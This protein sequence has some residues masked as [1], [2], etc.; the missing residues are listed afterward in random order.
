MSKLLTILNS[1]ITKTDNGALAYKST[2]NDIVDFFA[3]AGAM[4]EKNEC[5]IINSFDKAF[6][7]DPLVALKLLFYFRDCREGVG[8]RRLFRI[9]SEHLAQNNPNVLEK[10][11][12][13]IPHFGRWD[14]LLCLL[15]TKCKKH[16]IQLIKEQ[17]DH[18]IAS[19]PSLLGKWLPS[20]NTSSYKTQTL[21]RIICKELKINEKQYRKLLSCLRNKISIVE[22]KISNKD[23][24]NIDYESVPSQANLKYMKAFWRNDEERYSDFVTKAV[25]GEK[26]IKTKTLMPYEIIRRI[27]RNENNNATGDALWN[28]LPNYA[29]NDCDAIVVADTS[30]SMLCNNLLPICTAISLAI[31]FAER[32]KGVFANHFINFSSRPQLIKIDGC[33]I[34]AKAKYV[35]HKSLIDNT[36]IEAVFDLIL[37]TAIENQLSDSD[38]PERIIIISDMQFDMASTHRTNNQVLFDTIKQ[39]WNENDYKM[40]KLVYWNVNATTTAHPQTCEDENVQFVSGHSA[41]IFN[42]ILQDKFCT[43][44]ELI[45]DIVNKKRYSCIAM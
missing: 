42:E 34:T 2:Q 29:N 32:N 12:I 28:N 44:Y 3:T 4:R 43:P 14:D 30:G 26:K 35:F 39:K 33:D 21:G 25:K 9:I 5:D 20:I 41:T 45:L 8:E 11:L 36:N 18:D 24:S 37:N 7:Q 13:H 38:I 23:Y 10:N 16:V 1:N 19:E 17:I 31:Y 15:K 6:A 40:P 27:L 22:T